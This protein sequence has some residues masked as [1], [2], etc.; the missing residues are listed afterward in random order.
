MEELMKKTIIVTIIVAF[1]SISACN[2]SATKIPEP[3]GETATP[4]QETIIA[5][6]EA[7][8]LP[9]ETTASQ[10]ALCDINFDYDKYELRVD[11]RE[12]LA[13]HAGVLEKNKKCNVL[14]EGHCDERGTIEYNLAL[15][16]KRAYAVENYLLNYGI[17]PSRLTTVSYGKE[18]PLVLGS[19]EGAW[20]KNRRAAFI[21]A[22]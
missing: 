8:A 11:M 6:P 10:I 14:I 12:I 22:Q 19:N 15:G 13:E 2:K 7:L 5:E 17:S 1:L 16:E 3:T 21:I 18:K 4:V 9:A 20:L